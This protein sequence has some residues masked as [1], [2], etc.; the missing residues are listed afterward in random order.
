MAAFNPTAWLLKRE[1]HNSHEYEADRGAIQSGIDATQYQLLVIKEAVGAKS[2]AIANSFNY[3]NIKNRIKMMTKQNSK[4][5]ARWKTLL[6]VPLIAFLVLAFSQSGT[7]QNVN[8]P[9]NS[10]VGVWKLV[11]RNGKPIEGYMHIKII[12]KTQFAWTIYTSEGV[13]TS[14]AGGT[15]TLEG[16]VLY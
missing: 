8:R 2:Y 3:C 7:S 1:L 9:N 6:F 16:K 5:Q 15:Y 11:E 14:S 10:I 13:A 4:Q 12:T